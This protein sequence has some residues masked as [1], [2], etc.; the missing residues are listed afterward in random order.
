MIALVHIHIV[1]LLQYQDLLAA[2]HRIS[3]ID[4]IPRKHRQ[5]EEP[6]CRGRFL[7]MG[8]TLRKLFQYRKGYTQSLYPWSAL[9]FVLVI[10]EDERK[11]SR[12]MRIVAVLGH[13][14]GA[15]LLDWLPPGQLLALSLC[16]RWKLLSYNSVMMGQSAHY[17]HDRFSEMSKG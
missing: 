16:L 15:S 11:H 1:F 4:F 13:S 3:Q 7:Y 5:K 8:K 14:R 9:Q 17:V 6:L 12:S 2:P 10:T